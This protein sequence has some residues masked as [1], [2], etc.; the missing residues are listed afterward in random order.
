MAYESGH[1]DEKQH[2]ELVW[3]LQ[4]W[5]ELHPTPDV[6]TLAL[7]GRTYTPREMYD[8]V[9]YRTEFGEELSEF[10]VNTAE[11]YQTSPTAFIERIV[12]KTSQGELA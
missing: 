11:R 8:E 1:I 12:E 10:L 2:Q 3:G 9:E 4:D 7:M 6:P 5:V